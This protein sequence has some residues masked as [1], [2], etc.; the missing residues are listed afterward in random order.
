MRN[1]EIQAIQL[2]K[3]MIAEICVACGSARFSVVSTNSASFH[4]RRCE[5]C[6]T[7]FTDPKP[8]SEKLEASYSQSYYG[9]E[10][11]KFVSLLEGFVGWITQL[12]ARWIHQK[13]KA[14]SRIL[15]I[16]C[17]RGLLLSAL[18][19]LGHECHGT[20]R[21]SLA[22]KRAQS[23][24]GVK[25]YTVPLDRCNLE[26]ESFDLVILWHV[27]E[28]L[29]KPDQT[30][31]QVF[32]LLRTDGLLVLEVPNLSSL[33]SRLTG[34]RW[35]HLDIE[36]H[37]FHFTADGLRRLLSATGFI[38][39]KESTFSWEQCPFGVLQSFLN[40]LRLTPD[41]FYKLLKREVG[42]SVPLFLLHYFLAAILV[43]PAVTFAGLESLLRNGGVLRVT[44]RKTSGV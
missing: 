2:A 29:E 24:M 31:A 15:E 8:S 25:V 40:C 34:K 26:K 37:L 43:W 16:G 33:Q 21:S 30:L 3:D 14:H 38:L 19:R 10:N 4:L 13:I 1:R 5:Q 44:A 22:A 27:L 20:E 11:V 17:G 35:L 28:H 32:Q 23:I 42:V 6:G 18:A 9:P 36:R 41:T 7:A 39:I 12:R